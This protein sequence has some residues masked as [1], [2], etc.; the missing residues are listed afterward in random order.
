MFEPKQIIKAKVP[1]DWGLSVI[2]QP[3][4]LKI[5]A[6]RIANFYAV[7]FVILKIV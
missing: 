5:K 1:R 3:L 4:E 6:V 7:H 2:A